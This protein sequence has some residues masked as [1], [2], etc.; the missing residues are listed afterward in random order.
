MMFVFVIIL[1]FFFTIPQYLIQDI[2]VLGWGE[3]DRIIFSMVTCQARVRLLLKQNVSINM[4]GCICLSIIRKVS[5]FF[6]MMW[7]K[8]GS[9]YNT[10]SRSDWLRE[11]HPQSAVY[12]NSGFAL[13]RQLTWNL[14]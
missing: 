7:G 10:Y 6:I 4:I 11:T 5:V 14:L 1:T 12:I 13:V 3:C 8:A 9:S 2:S